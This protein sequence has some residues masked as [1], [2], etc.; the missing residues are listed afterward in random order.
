MK[1]ETIWFDLLNFFNF[2]SGFAT[3]DYNEG[4]GNGD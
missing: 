4:G 3:K 1:R 2:F